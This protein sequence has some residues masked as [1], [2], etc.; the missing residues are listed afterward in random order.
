G[1][2]PAPLRRELVANTPDRLDV[3]RLRRVKLDLLAQAAD[4]DGD[5]AGVTKVADVP[6]GVEELLPR[7]DLARV[8]REEEQQLELLGGEIQRRAVALDT[9]QARVN[10]QRA[11]VDRIVEHHR[12]HT[13]R[14]KPAQNRLDTQHHLARTERLGHVVVRA[15]CE[16]SYL[17]RLVAARRQQDDR[18]GAVRAQV[19]ADF[20]AIQTGQHEIQNNQVRRLLRHTAQGG[21]AV[22]SRRDDEAGRG[23]VLA[24]HFA[25]ARLVVH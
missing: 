14:R 21:W 8:S 22:L 15:S 2:H 12:G 1:Q 20:Q 6:D 17:V 11:E 25:D 23:E 5:G 7:E 4:V 18:H 16:T 3:P 19:A 24:E 13:A 9:A 10:G